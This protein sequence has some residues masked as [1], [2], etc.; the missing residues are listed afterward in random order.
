MACT[1]PIHGRDYFNSWPIF[2]EVRDNPLYGYPYLNSIFNLTNATPDQ[3][4][5]EYFIN[6]M[7]RLD[8]SGSA[9]KR[10]AINDLWG[11]MAK[12][13]VTWDFQ[14]QQ[15]LAQANS[16]DGQGSSDPGTAW[17]FYQRCRTPLV[18]M[19]GAPGWYRPSREHLPQEFGWNIIPLQATA[20]TTVTCNFQ[21]QCDPVRQSDWRACLVAV[22]TNVI[23]ANNPNNYAS[24]SRLW[25]SGANSI[26]L[27]ADQ[28]QL[29][30]VVIATPQAIGTEVMADWWAYLE[31]AGLQ[32]PYAV[33]FSNAAPLNVVEAKPTGV[34]WKNHTNTVDGTICKNIASTATVASTAY[35]SSNA[36]V[37][38]SAQVLGSASIQDYAVVRDSAQVSGNAVVSGHGEVRDSA[39]VSGYAKVRDWGRVFGNAQVYGYA[40]VI[41]HANCGD[42]GNVVSGSAV[43]KGT[44]YVYSP[45]A[46][47]GCLIMDGD[48][49][50]G[51]PT[52]ASYGVHFGWQ[53]GQ[54][55]SIFPGLTNNN[56]QYCGL[57]FEST[58]FTENN[59]PYG[60]SNNP[61]FALDQYGINHGFLMNGCRSAVDTGTGARGGYV[62]PL[63]GSNQYVELHYSVND[64]N[65]TTIAVWF[66]WAGGVA[67][68]RIWSMGDGANKVMYLTPNDSGTGNLRFLITDG[69][70]TNYLDGNAVPANVWTHVAIVF[71]QAASNSVLYV[72]GCRGGHQQCH[73][74]LSGQPE[75]PADGQ[76]ELSGPWQRR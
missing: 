70:T 75:R 46:F 54:N 3:Q 25:N 57:T 31:F 8:T 60:I 51:T 58:Q 53:W 9:D 6:R 76:C 59:K 73:Y 28:N 27:S 30:L 34:T 62:L 69:R 50:N 52:P 18:Q 56:Y 38:G 4:V 10:G 1:R 19:P 20:G 24:Y 74:A 65:D 44:T 72:N 37:L 55:P 35:V 17:Y 41:E 49:A 42:S 15:W 43:I 26:T 66:K 32:F 48:S 40:K 33:S 14:R 7:I 64:F 63:N 47:N 67:D 13:L 39:Q 29:Y 45:S 36:M 16:Q 12:R 21:P 71:A 5:N 23:S 22:S 11:D 68:Q 2:E 61:V